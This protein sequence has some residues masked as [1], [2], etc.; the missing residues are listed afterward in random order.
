MTDKVPD[1]SR[2][3]T[4]SHFESVLDGLED[5]VVALDERLRVTYLNSAAERYFQASRE[6]VI[7]TTFQVLFDESDSGFETRVDGVLESGETVE[8][9]YY[10]EDRDTW[11]AVEASPAPVGIVVVLE[12]VTETKARVKRLERFRTAIDQANDSVWIVDPDEPAILDVNETACEQLGYSCSEIRGM[13]P[14]DIQTE[15]SSAAEWEE[16]IRSIR[17]GGS[18]TFEGRHRRRDGTTFPVEVDLSMGTLADGEEILVA[19]ARDVSERRER[20]SELR[21]LQKAVEHAGHAIY[22]TDTD[23]TIEYVNPAFEEITGYS[24]TEAIGR[25][26][27]ILQ[28]G[29]VDDD[30]YER[31]WATIQGG[32]VFH[33][34][35]PNHSKNG[36]LYWADQVIAPILDDGEPIAYV[37][38]QRDITGRVEK[39]RELDLLWSLVDA[40]NDAVYVIDPETAEI[41]YANETAAEMLGYDR[42]T[43]LGLNAVDITAFFESVDEFRAYVESSDGSETITVS[44]EHVREDGTTVP[45]EVSARTVEFEGS[46]YRIAIA[47]DVTERNA[48]KRALEDYQ[49]GLER[50]NAV[51]LELL[52]TDSPEQSREYILEATADIFDDS[53]VT[54]LAYDKAENVL[55]PA[56][57]RGVEATDELL[58]TR[59]KPGESVVWDA[60]ADSS[61]QVVSDVTEGW[62]D[63]DGSET[64]LLVPIAGEGVLLVTRRSES[65]FEERSV[66]LG[67]LLST[68]CEDAYERLAWKTQL[69]DSREELELTNERLGE[70]VR[71]N[72]RVRRLQNQLLDTESRE[73]IETKVCRSLASFDDVELVWIGGYQPGESTVEPRTWEGPKHGYLDANSFEVSADSPEP[74]VRAVEERRVVGV[75]SIAERMDQGAWYREALKRGFGSAIGVPISHDEVLYGVL[76]LYESGPMSFVEQRQVVFEELGETIARAITM[77]EQRRSLG[78]QERVELQFET[79]TVDSLCAAFARELDASLSVDGIVGEGEERYFLYGAVEGV[80]ESAIRSAAAAIPNIRRLRILDVDEETVR[81]ELRT[82]HHVPPVTIIESGGR[83]HDL[84]VTP[85]SCRLVVSY[86]EGAQINTVIETFLRRHPSWELGARRQLT[87]QAVGQTHP[88]QERLTD[89]QREILSA[90]LHSGYFEW[91]RKTTGEE[92]AEMFDVSPPTVYRHLRLALRELVDDVVTER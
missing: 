12:D 35:V 30:Y 18:L 10:D 2:L 20:L 39:E 89:R 54:Y 61:V 36:T 4:V 60:F 22:I 58:A 70:L 40:A 84:R 48:R 49:R 44:H 79:D 59:L 9:D 16:H 33:E 15:H 13:L 1:F 19:V 50:L 81:F 88:V 47:R 74:A 65:D 5:C 62:L 14:S 26:P 32:E 56:A 23:G 92:L 45:V 34:E 41:E 7:G 85:S 68:I 71:V 28:S 51:T 21:R 69:Q 55:R 29:R 11:L 31:L 46:P 73:A 52:R 78:S 83:F 6:S 43:V 75:R 25:T 3:S 66:E 87:E 91:H 64:W 37:A 17:E 24:A 76:T 86:H 8:F 63:A 82:D 53:G 27:R 67:T 42:D 57:A 80:S 38:I 72:E 90:A 77:V